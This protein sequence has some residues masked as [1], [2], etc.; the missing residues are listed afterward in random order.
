MPSLIFNPKENEIDLNVTERNKCS[1][2][3]SRRSSLLDLKPYWKHS[4]S[5]PFRYRSANEYKRVATLE[6]VHM[7]TLAIDLNPFKKHPLL[8]T[9]SILSIT[10]GSRILKTNICVL[11]LL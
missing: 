3:V 8:E 10:S 9:T 7:K 6:D 2:V 5:I 4:F 11:S 1:A